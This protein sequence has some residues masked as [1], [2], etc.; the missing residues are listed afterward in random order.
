MYKVLALF[1][2]FLFSVG[3]VQAQHM[4][5]AQVV[6]YIKDAQK[7]GKSETQI[8]SGLV[9]RGVTREQVERIK[10]NLEESQGSDKIAKGQKTFDAQAGN[11]TSGSLDE[12]A[13][14]IA[15]PGQLKSTAQAARLV[16]GR[17]IFTSKQL[18]FEP[19]MNLA[20]PENYKLGPGDE[21]IIDI[22]GSSENSIRETISPE[23]NIMVSNIGPVYLNG[24][25][26]KEANSYLQREFSKIYAGIAGN[27]SHINLT[28][29]QI[30]SIQINV[31]GEVAM[32]GTYTLSSF[33]SVFHALYKAGGVSPIGSLRSI[34]LI[35][36][37][38]KIAD[39]DIYDYILKGKTKD[40]IRLM[41]GDVI[42]IPPYDCLAD[43]SGKVKRPMF[44]EMKKGETLLTLI[45]YAGGFTGDAYKNSI[46]LLRQSGREKQIYNVDEVEYGVFKLMDGDAVTVGAVLERFKN[47]VEVRGAVFRQGLYELGDRVGTVKQL[48]QQ[49]EGLR[50]DAFLNRVLLDREREDFSH[51]MIPVDLRGIMNGT[52]ADIPLQRNDVLYIPSIHDLQEQSTFSIFGEVARPGTFPF[53]KNTTIKDIIIQAGGL[54]ESASVA[55]I[56]VSRRVKDPGSKD[57]T[58]VTGKTFTL[59]LKNGFLIGEGKDFVLEP[60]DIVF[61][62]RS[63]SYHRQQNVTV[64]GEVLFSGNYAL[65]KKNERLSDLVSRAGGVTKDAFVKGARLSRRMTVEQI[66]QKQDAVRLADKGVGKDSISLVKLEQGNTY[67]VGIEL[68]KALANPG[69]DED[70]VLKEGDELFIPEFVSTVKINGEVMYPNTVLYQPGEKLSYYIEQA[71]GFGYKAQKKKVYIVYMNGTVSRV[72]RGSAKYIEPGC[73]IV[74]PSKKEKKRTDAVNVLGMSSSV[75]SLATMIATMVNLT[76]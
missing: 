59:E 8:T 62:R 51:Q 52:I 10:A 5:D 24:M 11:V 41:E 13:T 28:L 55:K 34:Q 2:V 65:S 29:G 38:K 74:V 27:S 73:E 44:Y 54:L 42:L 33:A 22:W 19:N 21:V 40:D 57:E 71:G 50:G 16:F 6:Q 72:K 31:M 48:V 14:D 58:N 66:K 68:E 9:R 36:N 56:D 4:S 67:S 46:R 30:R 64:M 75:A 63:P 25:T 35:R 60:F 1:F 70:L 17:N 76:K 61:V 32:P 49:A 7:S 20:T 45:R 23:G 26:I 69:S 37:G 43:I 15:D 39:I 3:T 53:A 47:K 18:S 12:I